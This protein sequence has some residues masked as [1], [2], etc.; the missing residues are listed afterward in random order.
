MRVRTIL[1]AGA[2]VLAAGQHALT[3]QRRHEELL[4]R[5]DELLTQRPEL[6]LHHVFDVAAPITDAPTAD[7]TPADSD[8]GNVTPPPP[9]A[10]V[11]GPTTRR[12]A[13]ILP[14]GGTA[15]HGDARTQWPIVADI[16]RQVKG[17]NVDDLERRMLAK[18]PT[19][20]TDVRFLPPAQ[21][22]QAVVRLLDLIT[23]TPHPGG[24]R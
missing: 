2:A 20:V 6:D 19:G 18:G 14:D 9:I 4:D 13:R 1:L 3:A 12:V 24:D 11:Y 23:S 21:L 10:V 22:E 15:S 7:V 17:I 8:P 16:A 5:L